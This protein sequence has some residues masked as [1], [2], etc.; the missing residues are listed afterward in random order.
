[1]DAASAK[2]P[3]PTADDAVPD[4]LDG[5]DEEAHQELRTRFADRFAGTWF[6]DDNGQPQLHI[7]LVR[8]AA[9]ERDFLKSFVQRRAEAHANRRGPGSRRTQAVV[10]AVDHSA[11]DLEQLQA[12]V[13]VVVRERCGGSGTPWSSAFVGV[14][15]PGNVVV[16]TTDVFDQRLAD[17]IS[18]RFAGRPIRYDAEE[19]GRVEFRNASR[20][21]APPYIGGL[22]VSASMACTSGYVFKNGGLTPYYGSTAGHCEAEGTRSTWHIGGDYVGFT[23]ER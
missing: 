6:T 18:S 20:T 13:E 5:L 12:E 23:R 19:G 3:G 22:S 16:L 10:E 9:A 14:D 4:A 2:Q 15:A 21:N 11:A 7:G 1:M 8:P 17:E